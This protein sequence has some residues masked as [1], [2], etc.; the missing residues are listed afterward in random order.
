[1]ELGL[2]GVCID[3]DPE[4]TKARSP[5][6]H[7]QTEHLQKAKRAASAC[8]RDPVW[9]RNLQSL[10]ECLGGEDGASPGDRNDAFRQHLCGICM[11]VE[12][13]SVWIGRMWDFAFSVAA[14]P[15]P[16]LP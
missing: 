16:G 3:R 14:S 12:E 1:M 9:C 6:N 2:S 11:L 13:E 10:G 5:S 7:E 8:P 15:R 4:I